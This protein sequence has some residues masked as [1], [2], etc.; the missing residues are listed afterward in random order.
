MSRL[1]ICVAIA[2]SI[3]TIAPAAPVPT[4]LMPKD[5]PFDFPTRVGTTWVY[6]AEGEEKTLVISRSEDEPGGK[7]VTTEWVDSNGKRT[8]RKVVLV[9]VKGVFMTAEEGEKYDQPWCLLKLPHRERQSWNSK[10]SRGR[11][12][13]ITQTTTTGPVERVK[14]P[15]GEF[16]AARVDFEFVLDDAEEVH[17]V[18]HWYV[19]GVGLVK[20]DDF[21]KLKSFKP[22]KD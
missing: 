17:K 20:S 12:L 3:A 15:A 6:D 10:H 16:E 9:T 22:G 8:P 1:L 14:V 18:T 13:A 2:A 5:P 21:L 7:L 11:K 4:H 19:H